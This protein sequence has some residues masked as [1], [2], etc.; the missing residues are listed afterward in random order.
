MLLLY[1]HVVQTKEIL[2]KG[3]GI[4]FKKRNWRT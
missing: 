1:L 4:V 3:V 2:K